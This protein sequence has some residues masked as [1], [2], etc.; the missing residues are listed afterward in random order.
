MVNLL[1]SPYSKD[2]VVILTLKIKMT[3]LYLELSI[4]IL[5]LI[6]LEHTYNVSKMHNMQRLS[7]YSH[8]SSKLAGKLQKGP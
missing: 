8:H 4:K 5:A 1:V 2:G 3:T 7:S 6:S